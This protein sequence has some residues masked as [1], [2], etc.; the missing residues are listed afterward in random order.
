MP[1][2]IFGEQVKA[3]VVLKE[4]QTASEEEIRNYCAKHLADYK[5]PKYILFLNEPL[6]RNPGG[7]VKKEVLRALQLTR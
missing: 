3:Y 6:P 1:D 4:G 7:K 2:K 5:V